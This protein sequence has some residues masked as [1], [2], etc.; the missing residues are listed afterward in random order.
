MVEVENWR[1]HC[2][3]TSFV[4]SQGPA[5]DAIRLLDDI[6]GALLSLGLSNVYCLQREL[7]CAFLL[8]SSDE[9]FL[10]E[11]NFLLVNKLLSS[12]RRIKLILAPASRL[13][14]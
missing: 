13:I 7:A 8:V 12:R 9:G 5:E 10:G 11:L 6:L 14:I 4:L 2:S 1:Q 3:L